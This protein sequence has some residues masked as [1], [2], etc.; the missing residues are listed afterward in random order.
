MRQLVSQWNEPKEYE[1]FAL[2]RGDIVF[3]LDRPFIATGIKVARV[4]TEDIPSLLLQRVGR[5]LIHDTY[6][7]RDYLFLWLH[8]TE[9]TQQIDPGRSNGV[10]HVSSKQV[11]DANIA[12]PPPEEQHR[13]LGL[14]ER[15][16]TI[17]DRLE[18]QLATAQTESSRLLEAVLHKALEETGASAREPVAH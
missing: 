10:P 18:T 17:C 16:L 4:S 6:L 2:N 5:F 1:R 12:V 7:T 9:F 14:V 13:L 8:S 11:E 3:S 15:V